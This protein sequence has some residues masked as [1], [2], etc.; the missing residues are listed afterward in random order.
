MTFCLKSKDLLK[1]SLT[2]YA[3][4]TQGMEQ[5]YYLLILLIDLI[6]LVLFLRKLKI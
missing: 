5:I 1:Y 2:L 3:I 4:A 6:T